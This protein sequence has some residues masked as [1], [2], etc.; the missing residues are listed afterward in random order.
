MTETAD[1]TPAAFDD[2]T[3]E[4]HQYSREMNISGAPK[5]PFP[6][7]RDALFVA[8]GARA[9]WDHGADIKWI[10]VRG[11]IRADDGRRGEDVT[12]KY[13]TPA[14]EGASANSGNMAPTWLLE[15]F[16]INTPAK[17]QK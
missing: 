5:M 2:H 17:T 1:R 9:T 4:Y 8:E 14:L 13:F 11:A 7:R 3:T 12:V 16:G 6:G 10:E 15:L